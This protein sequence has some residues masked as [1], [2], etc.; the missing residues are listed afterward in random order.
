LIFVARATHSFLK[1]IKN[2]ILSSEKICKKK[3]YI[4]NVVF[5]QRAKF[6]ME[7]TYIQ[8]FIKYQNLTGFD[9]LKVCTVHDYICDFVIFAL[10]ELKFTCW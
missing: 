7:I 8:G 4:S 2:N 5:Y 6:Y 9:I 10:F 3:L 1:K